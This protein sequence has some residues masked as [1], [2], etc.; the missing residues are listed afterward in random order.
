MQA[1]TKLQPMAEKPPKTTVGSNDPKPKSAEITPGP[2]F[3]L[4]EQINRP[5]KIVIDQ[6]R[7]FET[8]DISD[9][10]NRMYTMD[11]SIHNLVNEKPLVG[12]VIS[13]KVFQGDNLMLHKALDV[14]E[15]GDV[16]VVDTSGSNRNGIVRGT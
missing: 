2:G 11:H 6:I 14:A 10:F 1:N 4:R 5:Q 8:A 7:A 16:V 12:P 3:Q 15:P 9:L 13:V